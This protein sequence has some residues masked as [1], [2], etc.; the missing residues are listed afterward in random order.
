MKF[1]D[2]T[3]QELQKHL[4]SRGG[5]RIASNDGGPK[6]VA[7]YPFEGIAISEA[8]GAAIRAN[9]EQV[10][11]KFRAKVTINDNIRFDSK[12][13]ARYYEVL[14]RMKDAGLILFFLRQ[15]P[16][17]LPGGTK[18][19][20]DFQV[21]WTDGTVTFEDTKG[22]LTDGFNV[23]RREVEH[24]YP[25]EIIVLQ[26]ADVKKLENTHFERLAA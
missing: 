20:I 24:L 4:S 26:N 2:M 13:E 6:G 18:L 22:K 3:E 5:S 14:K 8:S 25:I 9:A 1:K 15:V 11:H 10:R 17:H 19:V 16:L 7:A 12:L 21:F 23:K